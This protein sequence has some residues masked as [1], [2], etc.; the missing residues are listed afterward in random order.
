MTTLSIRNISLPPTSMTVW[1]SAVEWDLRWSSRCSKVSSRANKSLG[2]LRRTLK[3]CCERVKGQAY[4]S[5]FSRYC[6]SSPEILWRLFL[7]KKQPSYRLAALLICKVFSVDS[8]T[9]G[10]LGFCEISVF[11]LLKSVITLPG[12]FYG[13]K[14]PTILTHPNYYKYDWVYLIIVSPWKK[15]NGLGPGRMF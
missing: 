6:W 7:W 13:G 9:R 4:L 3:P 14:R 1:A 10:F 5:L 11:Y 2:L 12:E 8:I 15:F